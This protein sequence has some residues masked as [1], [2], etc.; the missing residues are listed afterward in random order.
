M[1]FVA[2]RRPRL[3]ASTRIVVARMS[4]GPD[5]ESEMIARSGRVSVRDRR[6][7]PKRCRVVGYATVANRGEPRIMV[8]SP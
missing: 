8:S 3:T 1:K 4:P 6:T 2:S 5:E 7:W